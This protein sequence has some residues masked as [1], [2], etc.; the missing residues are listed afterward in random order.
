[1]ARRNALS[2]PGRAAP[3]PSPP[4]GPPAWLPVPAGAGPPRFWRACDP[5]GLVRCVMVICDYGNGKHGHTTLDVRIG[6]QVSYFCSSL[7]HMMAHRSDRAL[8]GQRGRQA[9]LLPGRALRLRA[10]QRLRD[11]RRLLPSDIFCDVDRYA[12]TIK[13]KL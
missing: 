5:L 1:M 7:R 12:C 13:R 8:K 10:M 9:R 2:P 11:M 4:A 6:G 3:G